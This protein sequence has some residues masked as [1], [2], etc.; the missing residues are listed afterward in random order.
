MRPTQLLLLAALVA[1]AAA[2]FNANDWALP[3]NFEIQP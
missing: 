1:G 2:A 3:A